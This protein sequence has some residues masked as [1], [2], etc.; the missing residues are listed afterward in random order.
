VPVRDAVSH[1]STVPQL[2]IKEA[3]M[4]TS[5]RKVDYFY[6]TLSDTPGQ[7]ATILSELAAAGVNLLA[8]SGFPSG[9]RAQLDLVPAD[10]ARLKAAARKLKLKLSAKKSGFIVDGDDR[11]GAM[12]GILDALATARINVTAM[13]AVATGDGRFGAIFWVKPQAVAKTA[14]LLGA[15]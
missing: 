6:V 5:V 4:S 13:D 9:R 10:P 2:F 15:R 8:F 3:F 1:A 7:G 12:A 11:L 14:K